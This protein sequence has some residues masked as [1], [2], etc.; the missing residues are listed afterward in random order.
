[1]PFVYKSQIYIIIVLANLNT[2]SDEF[3]QDE[4]LKLKIPKA[5]FYRKDFNQAIYIVFWFLIRNDKWKKQKIFTSQ[6]IP[7]GRRVFKIKK[8]WWDKIFKFKVK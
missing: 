1:M 8:D 7:I 6:T 5:F 4:F 3:D 2:G